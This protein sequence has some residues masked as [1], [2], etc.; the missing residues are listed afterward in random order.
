MLGGVAGLLVTVAIG[1]WLFRDPLPAL[2]PERLVAADKLW[3]EQGPANYDLDLKLSGGQTG[4]IHIEVR[5]GEV[6]AMTRNGRTPEQRRTWDYWSV[7]N[8]LDALGQELESARN[9]ER[10]FGVASASS[11]VLRAEFDPRYG[12]PRIYQRIVLGQL[13]ELRWEVT[14]FV[15]VESDDAR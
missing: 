5:D 11:V 14:S 7:E 12:Y 1:I 3:R 8:Q 6:T 9:P 10:A 4:L 15:P 13:S 2:T